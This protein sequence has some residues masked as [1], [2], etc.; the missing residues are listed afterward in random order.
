[1]CEDDLRGV[2]EAAARHEGLVEGVQLLGLGRGV[3][4]EDEDDA[5]R[6]PAEDRDADCTDHTLLLTSGWR[7]STARTGATRWRP[8]APP[9]PARSAER[10]YYKHKI[11][12]LEL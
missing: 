6:L 4:V 5:V 11:S 1:M 8:T 9:P 7:A 12:T 10:C 3:G 2:G